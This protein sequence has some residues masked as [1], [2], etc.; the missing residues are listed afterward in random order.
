MHEDHKAVSEHFPPSCFQQLPA[1]PFVTLGTSP[2]VPA[3]PLLE[4]EE[5]GGF[6]PL[7]FNTSCNTRKLRRMINLSR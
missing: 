2:A 3:G 1:E 6:F 4:L 5:L 7:V